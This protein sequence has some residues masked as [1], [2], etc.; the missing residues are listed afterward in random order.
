MFWGKGTQ[1]DLVNP[2]FIPPNLFFTTLLK[3][4]IHQKFALIRYADKDQFLNMHYT[5]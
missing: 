1:G 2:A 5:F 3:S 4:M